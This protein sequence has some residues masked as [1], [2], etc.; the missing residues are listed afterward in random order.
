MRSI[1]RA[2]AESSVAPTRMVW[3]P[4]AFDT[5]EDFV[6]AGFDASVRSRRIPLDL[7]F[8]DARA[9]APATIAAFT[10]GCGAISWRR[11]ARS[12]AARSGWPAFPSAASSLWIMRPAIRRIGTG[13]ACWRPIWA[14]ACSSQRSPTP[15]DSRPGNRVRLRIAT[16]SGE[17]GASSL[18]GPQRRAAAQMQSACTWGTGAK[19]ALHRRTP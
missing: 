1:F 3:L 5:P 17:Y 19:T 18:R 11:R 4:G 9:R 14:I 7:V 10:I 6:K 12:V 13:C 16:K 15:P 2:A 8:V